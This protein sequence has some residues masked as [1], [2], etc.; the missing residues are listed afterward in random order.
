MFFFLSTDLTRGNLMLITLRG[1]KPAL[2]VSKEYKLISTGQENG[3]PTKRI[4]FFNLTPLTT[5]PN[6]IVFRVHVDIQGIWIST[7]HSKNYSVKVH[8]KHNS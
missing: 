3:I 2:Q 1:S 8:S 4:Q 5:V 7:L 6:E